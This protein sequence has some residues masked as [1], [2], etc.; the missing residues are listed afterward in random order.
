MNQI[1]LNHL[2]SMNHAG[3]EL[4]IGRRQWHIYE[5]ALRD[6]LFKTSD[7]L[8]YYSPGIDGKMH[9]FGDPINLYPNGAQGEIFN[10]VVVLENI[11]TGEALISDV[12]EGVAV[13]FCSNWIT[14]S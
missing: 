1:T 11:D 10:H 9:L 2:K 7:F 5:P 3:K 12:T 14:P 6:L 4:G 8:L 13:V